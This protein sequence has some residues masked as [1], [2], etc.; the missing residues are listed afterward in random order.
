MGN[1][2]QNMLFYNLSITEYKI[3][4]GK[5][6]GNPSLQVLVFIHLFL[7]PAR[8]FLAPVCLGTMLSNTLT[9]YLEYGPSDF[10]KCAGLGY[11]FL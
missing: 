8:P 7:H 3:Q 5:F 11:L 1:K 10:F 9:T 4:T 6:P 2:K